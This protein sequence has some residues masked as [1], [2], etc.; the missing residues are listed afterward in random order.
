[1]VHTL[2]FGGKVAVQNVRTSFTQIVT[3]VKL[4]STMVEVSSWLRKHVRGTS[5]MGLASCIKG[6]VHR[7]QTAEAKTVLTA[8]ARTVLDGAYQRI[9][10]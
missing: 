8:A 2:W 3:V 1:M 7:L 4:S 10:F 9:L 6:V 5:V